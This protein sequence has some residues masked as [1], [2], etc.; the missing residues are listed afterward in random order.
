MAYTTSL[1]LVILLNGIGIPA[2]ILPGIIADRYLGPLNTFLICCGIN[3]ITLWCWLS[4]SSIP[5]Y[6]VFI[7]VYGLFCAAFQSL[8]P[9]TIAAIS[10]DITKTGTRL[11][12]AFGA[13]G[14]SALVGGPLSGALLNANG[15]N[16]TAPICWAS[17]STCAGWAFILSARCVKHGW[18]VMV[19]C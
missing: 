4:V 14:F 13:I 10:P 7:T 15:G 5:S 12:M 16:Y 3:C 18:R 17:A 6:Y 1:N 2:R 9:T 8:F 19:K 11:G